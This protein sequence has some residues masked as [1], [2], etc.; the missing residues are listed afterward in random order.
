MAKWGKRDHFT[1]QSMLKRDIRSAAT[2][3]AKKGVKPTLPKLKCLEPDALTA[4]ERN[5]VENKG[6]SQS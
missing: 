2:R 5:D 1:P 4:L 3:S 6:D